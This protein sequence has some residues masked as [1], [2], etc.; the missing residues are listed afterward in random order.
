MSWFLGAGVLGTL[1]ALGL[2][3]WEAALRKKAETNADL[4]KS[5]ALDVLRQ[6]HVEQ[7]KVERLENVITTLNQQLKQAETDL[8]SCSEP[9]VWRDR[10]RRMREESLA[11][12]AAS[13]SLPAPLAATTAA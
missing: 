1:V 12:A 4:Q 5:Q 7:G 2:W 8:E 10:L 13:A 11:R 3:R 6:F 9:S